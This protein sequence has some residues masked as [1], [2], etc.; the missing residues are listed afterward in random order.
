ME[1]LPRTYSKYKREDEFY[2]V[3]IMPEEAAAILKTEETIGGMREVHRLLAYIWA[4]GIVRH[5]YGAL[6]G[7]FSME[8]V[9]LLLPVPRAGRLFLIA[10]R[11][12]SSPGRRRAALLNNCPFG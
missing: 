1:V 4:L 3:S 9:L 6:R 2:T 8:H 12:A 10:F 7:R 11:C 5:G